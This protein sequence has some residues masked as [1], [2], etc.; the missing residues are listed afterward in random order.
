MTLSATACNILLQNPPQLEAISRVLFRTGRSSG[1]GRGRQGEAI[2][3][4][5]WGISVKW[6]WTRNEQKC[7]K[8]HKFT[9]AYSTPT[10]RTDLICTRATVLDD[11]VRHPR[12]HPHCEHLTEPRARR[13]ILPPSRRVRDPSGCQQLPRRLAGS[14]GIDPH[15]SSRSYRQQR[16]Q[17]GEGELHTPSQLPKAV[18]HLLVFLLTAFSP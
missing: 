15:P 14:Q 4:V 6:N 12:A 3:Y 8:R 9:Y 2:R 5:Y 17:A 16:A 18:E 13:C 7:I 11:S 1:T 10:T